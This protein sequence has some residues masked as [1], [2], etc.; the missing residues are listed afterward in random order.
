M[1]DIAKLLKRWHGCPAEL[2]NASSGKRLVLLRIVDDYFS[3]PLSHRNPFRG[4][5]TASG[6]ALCEVEN[7]LG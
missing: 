2:E 3:D 1:I 5:A 6:V 4:A 7:V